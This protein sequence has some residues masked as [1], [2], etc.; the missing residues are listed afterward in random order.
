[1]TPSTT[2]SIVSA[3]IITAATI[4]DTDVDDVSARPSSSND[5]WINASPIRSCQD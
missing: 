4:V 1:M 3:A 2:P 5:V